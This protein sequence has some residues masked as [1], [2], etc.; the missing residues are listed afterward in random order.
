M[1]GIGMGGVIISVLCI[2]TTATSSTASEPLVTNKC[3]PGVEY[4]IDWSAFMYFSLA[5]IVLLSNI[6]GFFVLK[7]LPIT[8]Y[9]ESHGG[10]FAR[11]LLL[12][13]SFT[14][15]A[16]DVMSLRDAKEWD[17]DLQ[18]EEEN[19]LV[20]AWRVLKI[21]KLPGFSI[22]FV[23]IV[24]YSLYPGLTTLITTEGWS[25]KYFAPAMFLLFNLGDLSGRLACGF[26]DVQSNVLMLSKWVANASLLRVIFLPAFMFC[27][28]AGTVLPI[29]FSHDAW[30]FL[31]MA[32]F[33][34]TSGLLAT[35]SMMIAPTLVQFQDKRTVGAIMTFLLSTG[36]LAGSCAS[37]L[38][39]RIATGSF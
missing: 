10:A 1:G 5:S 4:S 20:G 12:A 28:V 21:V 8:K 2:V 34:F 36:V 25:A 7:S 6:A 32:L 9:Y 38:S 19:A 15:S 30:P 39:V 35:M 29:V 37:F 14:V 22:L 17:L 13:D 24:T 31:F 3:P 26:L 11:P 16:G 27:N 23:F 33:S 18:P